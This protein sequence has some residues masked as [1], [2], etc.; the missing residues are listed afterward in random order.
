MTTMPDGI[1]SL[2]PGM[3][4]AFPGATKVAGYL[5][6]T[7]AW[8]QDDWALFPH[9]DHVTITVTA[10]A[11]IGDVLDVETGDATPPQ[12][13][14]WIAMRKAAG[15]FRPTI[16][17]N[18]S[19]V[20]AVRQGTGKFILGQDYDL[21]VAVYDNSTA[22]PYAGS[23]AKQYES[24]TDYDLNE[25]YDE[26]WPYRTEPSPVPGMPS[27]FSQTPTEAFTD[28]GWHPVPGAASY[29]FQLVHGRTQV[30]RKSVTSPNIEKVPTEPGKTYAWH[31]SAIN[32]YGSSGWSSLRAFVT[33]A[34]GFP[35]P[36]GLRVMADI[37][38]VSWDAVSVNGVDPDGYEVSVLDGGKIIKTVSVKGT[39]AVLDGLTRNKVYELEVH[40]TG[41]QGVPGS[42]K[43][44]VTV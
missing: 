39:T 23:V 24:T 3:A 19:T 31:V 1:N 6:G 26:N 43:I 15:L 25:V 41:G 30:Y 9:A 21:W 37:I 5:N 40:A 35:V 38:S 10:S 20:P 7:Y 2:A 17:C 4:K 16:Y 29:D 18:L 33:P 12:A 34:V 22:S 44:S 32:S 8:S 36:S 11:D 27:G 14:A 28:F 13:E 42:A